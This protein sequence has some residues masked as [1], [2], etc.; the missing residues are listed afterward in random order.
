MLVAAQVGQEI[1]AGPRGAIATLIA[2]VDSHRHIG[3]LSR[4]YDRQHVT[5]VRYINHIYID[6]WTY[7]LLR[8]AGGCADRTH[9]LGHRPSHTY[10]HM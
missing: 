8:Y 9:C 2:R 6:I 7:V 1:Y 10:M 3:W 4:S 5:W